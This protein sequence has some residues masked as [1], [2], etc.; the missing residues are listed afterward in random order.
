[1]L[2]TSYL[3]L[4]IGLTLIMSTTLVGAESPSEPAKVLS[5]NKI[6]DKAPHNAFTDLVRFNDQWFCVFRE[7]G[8]HIS[9]VGSLRV[10]KS[11]DGENW[12]SA[13]LVTSDAADLR[14][15][16]ISV[17]P[18]GKLCLAG[19]GAL[20]Q[21][22]SAKH[23]SYVWY[24]ED[25]SKWSD[26]I[27]VGDPNFWLWRLTWHDG[28]AYG[29][30]YSTV[31]PRAA[32]LYKSEDGKTFKQVGED[33]AIQGYMNETGL[34]FQ[35]DGTARCLI[36]RD[37]NPSDALLGTASPPYTDWTWK[38]VGEYVGGPQMIQLADGRFIVGGR[39]KIGGAKTVL[40]QLDPKTA[41][42]TELATLPSGGDTSYPGL[43]FQDGKL[44]VSYYSSHEGKTSIYLAR[45]QLPTT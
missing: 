40:W 15:A 3:G 28:A 33:F 41:K 10:L 12:E 43:V 34:V 31:A 29:V 18:D 11:T 22:A 37:G 16:K 13:A 1:M 5:V 2:Q 30:G 24:S 42:L 20:H 19:A 23:Q 32:R 45:V 35:E 6:W 17:T 44:W 8:G 9:K 27:E 39:K 21:P 36:R 26:A 7:G 25:G 4:A 38:S 14:D